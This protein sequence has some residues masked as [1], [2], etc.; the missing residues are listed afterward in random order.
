MV[1]IGGSDQPH[2]LGGVFLPKWIHLDVVGRLTPCRHGNQ[3]IHTLP[4]GID[5]RLHSNKTTSSNITRNTNNP[6]F[7]LSNQNS[8]KTTCVRGTF[9]T[10]SHL[11]YLS[12]ETPL[13]GEVKGVVH[14]D[15]NIYRPITMPLSRKTCV[16]TK[17]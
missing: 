7:L 17:N 10:S 2:P 11:F 13:F 12:S 9:N 6:N 14:G 5:Q 8:S 4:T 3:E 1:E 15:D 16:A